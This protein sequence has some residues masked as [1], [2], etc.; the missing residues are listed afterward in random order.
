MENY[1]NNM[2]IIKFLEIMKKNIFFL[3]IQKKLWKLLKKYE[4][5]KELWKL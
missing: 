4:H 5:Y 2:K 3:E 1:E